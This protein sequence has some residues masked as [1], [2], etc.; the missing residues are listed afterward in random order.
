MKVNK[1]KFLSKQI[2]IKNIIIYTNKYKC[3]TN[4]YSLILT[5]IHLKW[6]KDEQLIIHRKEVWIHISLNL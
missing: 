4:E 6:F 5:I 2:N 1:L 3:Q